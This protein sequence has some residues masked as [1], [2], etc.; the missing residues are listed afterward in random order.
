MLRWRGS[1][2]GSAGAGMGAGF[3]VGGQ[4]A[5]A[6]ASAINTPGQVMPSNTQPPASSQPAAPP[7]LPSAAS[8]HAAIDG[9]SAGPFDM[10]ALASKVREGKITRNSLV[11][12]AGM[13]NWVAADTVPEL[14]ALFAHVPPPLPG[15]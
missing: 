5:G 7:P 4:M 12:K 13:A 10:A 1:A 8:F 11:W 3:A 2:L 15:A 6:I 9:A 14:Q